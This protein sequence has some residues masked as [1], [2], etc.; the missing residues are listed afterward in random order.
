VTVR[1]RVQAALPAKEG[2]VN[3]ERV[4]QH[5]NATPQSVRDDKGM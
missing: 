2:D 3:K 5:A 1:L 4:T